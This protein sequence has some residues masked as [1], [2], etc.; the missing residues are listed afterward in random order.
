MRSHRQIPAWS[1]EQKIAHRIDLHRRSPEADQPNSSHRRRKTHE[2]AASQRFLIS[3]KPGEKRCEKRR[4]RDDHPHIGGKGI[5]KRDIF[6]KIIK[7]DAAKPRRG[8]S[9]FLAPI[10]SPHPMRISQQQ[11]PKAQ[12]K[13]EQQNLHRLK[14]RQQDLRRDKSDPPHHH[15]K[16]SCQMARS[17]SSLHSRS[18]SLSS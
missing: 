17:L 14:I 4:Y 13:A 18:S 8:E 2:K 7:T 12:H 3:K 5:G 15:R 10:R 6:Q 16:Y 1:S 9:K 11:R